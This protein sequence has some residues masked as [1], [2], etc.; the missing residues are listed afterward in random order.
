MILIKHNNVLF[1]FFSD[2]NTQQTH[3]SSIN[4]DAEEDIQVFFP[5]LVIIIFN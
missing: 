2:H 3:S 5:Q 1:L 4:S